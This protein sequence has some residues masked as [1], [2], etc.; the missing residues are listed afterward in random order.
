MWVQVESIDTNT[1]F[2]VT[3]NATPTNTGVTTVS[4]SDAKFNW[5]GYSFKFMPTTAVVVQL[6]TGEFSAA[7]GT[8]TRDHDYL[9]LAL[10]HNLSKNTSTWVGYRNTERTQ[11]ASTSE[12]DV[13]ALGMRVNF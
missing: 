13:L 11:G 5:I 10:L 4:S 1:G 3:G 7:G 8:A 12:T 9:S 2:T 6:G